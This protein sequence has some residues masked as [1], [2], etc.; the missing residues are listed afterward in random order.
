[1]ADDRQQA[2]KK[3]GLVR[4][5][6]SSEPSGQFHLPFEDF[7]GC[8]EVKKKQEQLICILRFSPLQRVLLL[9]DPESYIIMSKCLLNFTRDLFSEVFDFTR[10]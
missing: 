2:P 3:K 7:Q 1:M 6:L 4:Y 10:F 8:S 9:S 5:E